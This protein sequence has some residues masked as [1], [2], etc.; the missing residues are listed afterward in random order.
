[1]RELIFLGVCYAI[2]GLFVECVFTGLH[3]LIFLK[4]RAATCKTYLTML[5]LYG[6]AG[7]TLLGVREFYSQQSVFLLALIYLVIIYAFE[8][9]Y[10]SFW[11]NVFGF[12]PWDYGTVRWSV[13]G[14]IRLDFAP[15][16][17]AL[18][19]SFEPL[20]LFLKRAVVLLA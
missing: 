6:V 10:G 13:R 5:P 11:K 18:A 3:A 2:T 20:T 15:F 9:G 1:M 14:Y 16:W 4:D 8:Y 19:L 7:L 17:Y 12:V